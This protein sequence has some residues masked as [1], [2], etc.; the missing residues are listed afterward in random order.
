M[1]V[2]EEE[3]EALPLNDERVEWRED[4]AE[5]DDFRDLGVRVQAIELVD[6]RRQRIEQGAMRE[7][8]RQPR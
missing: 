7:A 5:A 6:S 4:A 1:L 2:A 3:L 8:Q